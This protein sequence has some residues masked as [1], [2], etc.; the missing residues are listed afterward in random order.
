MIFNKKIIIGG[1]V[2]FSVITATTVTLV[3]VLNK[4]ETDA[5]PVKIKETDAKGVE[6]VVALIK[7]AS[8]ISINE[9]LIEVVEGSSFNSDAQTK[10][11]IN[12]ASRSDVIVTYSHNAANSGTDFK[13]TF[14]V[15]KGDVEKKVIKAFGP[16]LPDVHKAVA[17]IENANYTYD[18]VNLLEVK[19]FTSFTSGT[20]GINTSSFP[21]GVLMEYKHLAVNLNGEFTVEFKITKS[22]A[23]K[24]ITKK[25]NAINIKMNNLI[26]NINDANNNKVFSGSLGKINVATP[27][28]ERAQS[29]YGISLTIP[30]G[31]EV[32]YSHAQVNRNANFKVTF[33][34][35][36]GAVEKTT[37]K[38]F[39]PNSVIIHKAV[40]A[41]FHSYKYMF[42]TRQ[43]LV[44]TNTAFNS[45]LQKKLLGIDISEKFD[46]SIVYQ[47]RTITSDGDFDMTFKV[48]KEDQSKTI[49]KTFGVKGVDETEVN[50]IITTIE[51]VV[52]GAID[53]DLAAV[54]ENTLFDGASQT[55]YGIDLTIPTGV[56]ITYSHAQVNRNTD[57]QVTFKVK[58]GDVEKIVIKNIGPISKL[59]AMIENANVGA[60]DENLDLVAAGTLFN[61]ASQTKYGI[62]LTIPSGVEITYSHAQVAI[63][64]DFQVTFKVKKGD[65]EKIVIKAFGPNLPDVNKVIA[66]IKSVWKPTFIAGFYEVPTKSLNTLKIGNFFQFFQIKYGYVG[67]SGVLVEMSYNIHNTLFDRN[68]KNNFVIRYLVTKGTKS[69]IVTK[70][71][72]DEITKNIGHIN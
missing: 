54:I 41:I 62:D 9:N 16:N 65:V 52:V 72:N 10:Y 27:F 69:K 48:S 19:N 58:K 36:K 8:N 5:E 49:T 25:I 71:L 46:V 35:K 57:F 37:I 32:T 53:E 70:I 60:I 15:K 59:I 50:S 12:L 26:K 63:D 51:N 34:I 61:N 29:K 17:L 7:N 47:H 20:F 42:V 22:T 55:K 30:T 24:T 23:T 1:I 44:S 28:D 43:S 67:V 68:E 2:G 56:E 4:K 45:E 31:I 13:V 11:G 6:I 66:S 21:S 14:I 40:D 33:K 3:M 18:G 38:A 64:A 39:G